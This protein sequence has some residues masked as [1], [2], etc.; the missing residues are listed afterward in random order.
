MIPLDVLAQMTD[1]IF[2]VL[3]LFS[4]SFSENF[5]LKGDGKTKLSDG[6]K[7]FDANMKLYC[8]RATSLSVKWKLYDRVVVT[9][10]RNG[11]VG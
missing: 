9:T 7:T 10:V 4:Y 1:E 8:V 2:E 11:E 5:G 3:S 6:L